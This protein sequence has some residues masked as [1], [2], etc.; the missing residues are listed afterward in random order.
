MS[1]KKTP[2]CVDLDGT[3]IRSDVLVE[4]LLLLMKQRPW[5]T[6]LIPFWL[7]QGRSVLKQKVAE[8]VDLDVEKLPYQAGFVDFL[9]KEHAEPPRVSW[10]PFGLSTGR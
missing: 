10:R 9:R 5:T 7:L 6:F 1:D 4:S 3:L 8:R 2:L